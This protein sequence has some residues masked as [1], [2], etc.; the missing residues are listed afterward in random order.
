MF[1]LAPDPNTFFVGG[2]SLPNIAI[3]CNKCGYT[4]LHNAIQLGIFK[5]EDEKP[6]E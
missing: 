6:D 1:P 5:E 4:Y 3:I 2:P